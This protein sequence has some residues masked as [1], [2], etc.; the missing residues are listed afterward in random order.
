MMPGVAYLGLGSNL[1]D[2][3]ANLLAAI[4]K[5]TLGGVVIEKL[6]SVYETDPVGFTAQPSFFN[7][8]ARC[9]SSQLDPW[10][11]MR[12]CLATELELGRRRVVP[13][14]PRSI[15]LDLL[16]FDHYQVDGSRDGIELTIPHPRMHERRFVLL[17]LGEI[18]PDLIHPTLGVT[19]GV[20]LERLADGSTAQRCDR[21]PVLWS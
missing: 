15:D 14:G 6:S 5:L 19:I 1:G 8:V 13:G 7:L 12:L 20:L 11:L 17:P 4:A 2:R 18:D 9:R 10:G 21:L 3:G 16:L